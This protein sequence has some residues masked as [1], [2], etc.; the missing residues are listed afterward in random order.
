MIYENDR[1]GGDVVGFLDMVKIAV[2]HGFERAVLRMAYLS[3]ILN[4]SCRIDRFGEGTDGHRRSH[5]VR[6]RVRMHEHGDPVVIGERVGEAVADRRT[7]I[8]PDPAGEEERR[9]DHQEELRP[10]DEEPEELS[11]ESGCLADDLRLHIA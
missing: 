8:P 4:D 1:L 2:E 11:P 9:S 3:R 7:E 6:I 10:L 5:R